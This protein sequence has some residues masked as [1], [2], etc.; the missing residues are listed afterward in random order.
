LIQEVQVL[1]LFAQSKAIVG[2]IHVAA[3]PGTPRYTGSLKEIVALAADEARVLTTAGCDGLLIENMHDVPYLCG[4]VGPEIVAAMTAAAVAVRQASHL[5]LGV[6]ILAAANRE[7]LAV[8]HACGADFVRVEN[9][10]YAHVADEGLMPTADAG[11][12]LR[13]RRLI[14]AERVHIFAD[15][16]K[17]HASHALTADLPIAEAARTAEFFGADA[18]VVTGTTT[19]QP[20]ALEDL[21]AVRQAVTVPVCIGSGLTPENLP[22]F[23]LHADVFI[24]GSYLKTDGLWSNAIDQNRLNRFVDAARKLREVS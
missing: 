15:V 6:Q 12:L 16:K 5:P 18:V 1:P 8:A 24:V 7:A 17:K 10:A 4:A 13:Y 11:P 3:L 23:W 14:S 19:G 20:A 21:T 2:M 9:F 22:Q